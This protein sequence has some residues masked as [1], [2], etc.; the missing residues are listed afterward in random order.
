MTQSAEQYRLS[1]H[2]YIEIMIV[3]KK[4]KEKKTFT[5]QQSLTTLYRHRQLYMHTHTHAHTH[6]PHTYTPRTH[7]RT[8]H[9]HTH[10]TR[11]RARTHTH[12]NTHTHTHTHT[13]TH[14]NTIQTV[15]F[16]TMP[17]DSVEEGSRAGQLRRRCVGAARPPKRH[18]QRASRMGKP[19]ILLQSRSL[20]ADCGQS[21]RSK[22]VGKESPFFHAP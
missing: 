15:V 4:K 1:T 11:T 22:V 13:R 6:I 14:T 17:C 19:N 16:I 20:V 2:K 18:G 5:Y 21:H 10:T 12:T 8:H 3:V 7:A 9:K